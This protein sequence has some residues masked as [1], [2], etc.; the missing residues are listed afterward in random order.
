[1]ANGKDEK[2]NGSTGMIIAAA[3][4][5]LG[6]GGSGIGILGNQTD[7]A[8]ELAALRKEIAAMKVLMADEEMRMIALISATDTSTADR[9][10]RGRLDLDGEMAQIRETVHELELDFAR[11]HGH[12][13]QEN[14]I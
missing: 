12:K 14:G 1:M 3:V 8:D 11:T 9:F 10:R 4:A 7:T 5:A 13:P 2:K 6:V